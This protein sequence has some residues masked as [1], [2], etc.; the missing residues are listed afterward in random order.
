MLSL[1]NAAPALPGGSWDDS[2][3]TSGWSGGTNTPSEISDFDQY[4]LDSWISILNAFPDPESNGEGPS[5]STANY[6]INSN[7]TGFPMH[8]DTIPTTYDNSFYAHAIDDSGTSSATTNPDFA[9]DP[10]LLS[11]NPT[12]QPA[13]DFGA[14]SFIPALVTSPIESTSLAAGPITPNVEVPS[15]TPNVYSGAQGMS[16][17][18]GQESFVA[19]MLAI[20]DPMAAAST[21]LQFAST[22][23][24]SSETAKASAVE[25]YHA[26]GSDTMQQTPPRST[27]D[28]FQQSV[29]V[30]VPSRAST[31]RPSTHT[32]QTGPTP[33]RRL[34]TV[35]KQDI[36]ARAKERR[37]QLVG[38]IDRA[39]VELWETTIEQGVLAQLV[40]ENL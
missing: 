11:F 40:K 23:A 7:S 17:E 10:V 25:Q 4:A 32:S 2:Q 19:E 28:F 30:T 21:L 36:L 33:L 34:P 35:N 24:P 22:A 37:R 38:E 6:D 27:Y 18:P 3:S 15:P 14:M 13:Q 9:I 12:Q 8:N 1:F 26:T 39:K 31:E 16:F 29:P 5:M 20:Q